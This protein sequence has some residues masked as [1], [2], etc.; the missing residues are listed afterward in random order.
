MAKQIHYLMVA[1]HLTGD[2]EVLF[3]KT[4]EEAEQ[5]FRKRTQH[6]LSID[7]LE[8]HTDYYE[9]DD[10]S[11]R[12]YGNENEDLMAELGEV[13]HYF[14]VGTIE[15]QDDVNYYI[16]DFSEHVDESTITF[17]NRE[18]AVIRYNDLVDDGVDMCVQ[19]CDGVNRYDNNTWES[20]SGTL[21]SETDNEDGSTDA[22]FGFSDVY[23]T[24]RIGE[25]KIN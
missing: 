1:T 17:L 12:F 15:V 4:R 16:A 22:F 19:Y 2:S 6:L 7:G 10:W 20:D 21:F 8:E 24:Y 3:F 14:T 25:V 5:E 13:D 9:V 11:I 18:D 23:W